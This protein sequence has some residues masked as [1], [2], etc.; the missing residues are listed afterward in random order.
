ME[1]SETTYIYHFQAARVSLDGD[2]NHEQQVVKMH[3][4]ANRLTTL[5]PKHD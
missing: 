4:S 3:A 1:V 5:N 2:T